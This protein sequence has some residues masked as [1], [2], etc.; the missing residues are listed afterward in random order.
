MST[1]SKILLAVL[2]VVACGCS[3][4][5]VGEEDTASAEGNLV[6]A[7]TALES[8]DYASA[9]PKLTAA[10]ESPALNVDQ[11]VEALLLRAQCYISTGEVRNAEADIAE[12]EQGASDGA[13]LNYTKALLYYKR[14]NTG[15]GNKAF[16]AARK[17]D[18][19]LKKPQ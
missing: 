11:Y 3:K 10:I 6:A 15:A 13:L 18:P 19:S 17:I 14:G 4:P 8:G 1:L 16:S 9:L 12:A 5:Q 7:Q 2:L